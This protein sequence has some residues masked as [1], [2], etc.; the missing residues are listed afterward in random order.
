VK[1]RTARKWL[2]RYLAKGASGLTD[3]SSRPKRFAAGD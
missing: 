1:P 3:A 2:G